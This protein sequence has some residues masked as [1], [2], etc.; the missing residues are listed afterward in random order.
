MSDALVS[1]NVVLTVLVLAV[2][3]YVVYQGF[4]E[5][6]Q[7]HRLTRRLDAAIEVVARENYL[8]TLARYVRE[9]Q[10]E[11]LFVSSTL[12][13]EGDE[14]ALKELREARNKVINRTSS[15]YQA[16][17]P[18]EQGRIK[19][20]YELHKAKVNV[21]VS[22]GALNS[23]LNFTIIDGEYAVLGL[24]LYPGGPSVNGVVIHSGPL[25]HLLKTYYQTLIETSEAFED[26]AGRRIRDLRAAHNNAAL[27]QTW[28]DI[29]P[30][31]QE[32]LAS[33]VREPTSGDE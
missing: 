16:V 29:P 5:G 25:I 31:E 7:R 33:K 8:L 1:L 13:H 24:P 4:Q 30:D 10:H 15:T 11:V 2:S 28:T 21:R 20:G 3:A 26:Y 19:G 23:D 22:D 9:T 17:I 6:R 12:S 14:P 32:K 27:I 18:P